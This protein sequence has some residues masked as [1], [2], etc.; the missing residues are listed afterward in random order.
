MS[1]ETCGN[2]PTWRPDLTFLIQLVA[3][4]RRRKLRNYLL[5][6]VN[7]ASRAPGSTSLQWK[8]AS[9]AATDRM[10]CQR[11]ESNHGRNRMGRT[12]VR[13]SSLPEFLPVKAAR[14]CSPR[15]IPLHVACDWESNH[16]HLVGRS[17]GAQGRDRTTDTV[18]F[19]R[20]TKAVGDRRRLMA[21][22]IYAS[23]YQYYLAIRGRLRSLTE[24]HQSGS[25]LPPACPRDAPRAAMSS[26]G[27][28]TVWFARYSPTH[29]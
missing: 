7:A 24:R 27:A 10:V 9:A 13:F 8:H 12:P 4:R 29:C 14:G 28:T 1:K 11:W 3:R 2:A 23:K 20:L 6:D 25:V 18:I 17:H 22:S 26:L 19:S 16:R 5:V 21:T 15:S